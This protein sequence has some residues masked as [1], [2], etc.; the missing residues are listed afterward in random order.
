M[1]SITQNFDPLLAWLLSALITY[2]R[3]LLFAGV[4][5]LVFY[6]FWKKQ[7]LKIQASWPSQLRIKAELI[8]SAMS[9]VVFA[10][11]G[12]LIAWAAQN[13]WTAIY[14]DLDA[15]GYPYL[16]LSFVLLVVIHDAYFYWLH[17]SMHSSPL[18]RRFHSWHHRSFNP[19]PLT[20]LAFHPVEAFLEIAI[21]LVVVLFLPLHPL[22]VLLFST[23]SL[24]WNVVGHLG[25]EMFPAGF[26]SHWLGR[27]FNTSTHHNLHHSDGRYNFSLYFNWWDQWLGTNHP[28]YHQRFESVAKQQ[29]KQAR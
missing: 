12:M 4:A 20:A 17:R 6:Q 24:F 18:L 3:Y 14:H 15:F 25:Y 16:F 5:Y 7:S 29:L 10:A 9:A 1:L 23:F 21:I 28:D 26:T 27:Y 13:G 22:V 19:N 11:V 2:G 8:E